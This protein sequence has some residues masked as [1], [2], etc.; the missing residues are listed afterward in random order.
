MP[1]TVAGL[2]AAAGEDNPEIAGRVVRAVHVI[3]AVVAPEGWLPSVLEHAEG[4]KAT[5]SQR[6]N[7]LVVLGGLLYGARAAGGALSK[8]EL[9]AVTAVVSSEGVRGTDQ[10]VGP[11]R[12]GGL[13]T[14]GVL[15]NGR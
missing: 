11:L 13:G 9:S 2:G 7:A 6:A 10:G 8:S 12:W 15:Q 3:G 1:R 5:P 14:L 4:A